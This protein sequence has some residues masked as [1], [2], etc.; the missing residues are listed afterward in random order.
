MKEYRP[1]YRSRVDSIIGGVAGGIALYM[2]ID[3]LIIR[4]IFVVLALFGGGGVLIYALLWI[5]LPLEPFDNINPENYKNMEKENFKSEKKD[6]TPDPED[7]KP[8]RQDGNLI[9]GL[10]LITIGVIF[11]VDRF[12]PRI[13]FSDLWPLIL[14][15]AGIV[16]IR[17][18]YKKKQ[19]E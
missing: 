11:L 8:K 5:A 10:V 14:L 15:V 12:I 17:I 6:Q 19:K 2:N 9:A 7:Y 18:G 3:S 1:L 4:V 16:L 13:Y